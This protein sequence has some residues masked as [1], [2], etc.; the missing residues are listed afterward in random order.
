MVRIRFTFKIGCDTLSLHSPHEGDGDPQ[1]LPLL[2]LG[3]HEPTV[4]EGYIGVHTGGMDSTHHL[5]EKMS[6]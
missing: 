5:Q 2:P 1:G 4:A 3:R 6:S